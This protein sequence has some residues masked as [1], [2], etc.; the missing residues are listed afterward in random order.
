MPKSNGSPFAGLPDW[1]TLNRVQQLISNANYSLASRIS[2]SPDPRRDIDDECGYPKTDAITIDNY[3]DFYEREPVATRVVELLPKESWVVQPTIYEDEDSEQETAFE[4]AWKELVTG[5]YGEENFFLGEEGNPIWEALLQADILSGIG[6]YGVLLLGLDDG[7]ELSKPAKRA[8]KLLYLNSFS[9]VQAKIQQVESD[10]SSP[11]FGQPT[12]YSISLAS[13]ISELGASVSTQTQNVHWTRVVHLQDNAGVPRMRPVFN[14]LMDLRKTYGGSAEMYWR[15]AFPGMSLETHP[16]LG[17]DVTIDADDLRDT[18]ENYANGLQRYL[19]TSGMAVKPLAPQVVDPTQQINAHIQAICIVLGVPQRIFMGSERGELAS[20]QDLGSWQARMSA[21]QNNYLTPKVIV[22]LVNRLIML[23]VLPE[24]SEFCVDWPDMVT[25]SEQDKATIANAKV[26]AMAAYVGGG[27][28]ALITPLDFLTRILE[29]PQDEAEQMLESAE[30]AVEEKQEEQAQQQADQQ[31]LEDDRAQAD[32]DNNPPVVKVKDGEQLMDPRTGKPVGN[33]GGTLRP[34]GLTGNF[35]PEGCNQ[36]TGPGCAGGGSGG[37]DLPS[38]PTFVSSNKGN[39][40]ENLKA[41]GELEALAK[42]GDLKGLKAHPGTPSP[43]VQEYK[44]ALVKAVGKGGKPLGAA[45]APGSP[46]KAPSSPAKAPGEPVAAPG[47]PK[48]LTAPK[49]VTAHLTAMLPAV[50]QATGLSAA[51][52]KAGIGGD[53][54][55]RAEVSSAIL[56]GGTEIK[57]AVL[58]LTK[59]GDPGRLDKIGT[60]NLANAK[61]QFAETPTYDLAILNKFTQSDTPIQ[62]EAVANLGTRSIVCGPDTR[63]GSYR[64]ELGHVLRGALGGKSFANTTGMTKAIS[65]EFDKVQQRVEADPSGLKGKMTHEQYEEK[66]G[67]AG[68]R[69]LDNWE[70]NFAEHYRLYHREIYRDKHEGGNGKFIAGYRTRHPG[71]ARIF[72]AHYTAAALAEHLSTKE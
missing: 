62:G 71:M 37:G 42:A 56:Q 40:K 29:V 54:V 25:T 67:V 59:L 26:T 66:Y 18:L 65:D 20:S 1:I 34:F 41:V 68:R 49:A 39:V 72:D 70:E 43:K 38:K 2:R 28:E 35:N 63:I 8:K 5:L 46:A 52:I 11:R 3:N 17:G 6:R 44:A 24:P 23:G 27:V 60:G 14:R 15:G 36:H 16:Q 9:E 51:A 45:K 58:H 55:V 31:A 30:E 21:R 19:V 53:P 22:P 64:H 32:R 57:D 69:S 48:G 61:A 7:D 47:S 33:T 50:A 13:P 10:R 12:L 4:A